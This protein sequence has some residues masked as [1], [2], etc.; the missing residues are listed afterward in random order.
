MKHLFFVIAY[1]I[2]LVPAMAVSY[3]GSFG[4]SDLQFSTGERGYDL[5][6]MNSLENIRVVGAPQVPVKMMNFIIPTGMDVDDVLINVNSQT[7][8]ETYELLP[9]QPPI[10]TSD[11]WLP[12]P[13]IE[14]DSTYYNMPIYPPSVYEVINHGYFDG[15]ARIA[16][17]AIY[18]IQYMPQSH[19]VLLNTSINFSLSFQ[20][21]SQVPVFPVKRNSLLQEKYN[22]LLYSIVENPEDIQMYYSQ[23]PSTELLP[24]EADYVIVAPEVLIPSLCDFLTWKA[25]KGLNPTLPL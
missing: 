18:P 17:I 11:D 23:P 20:S 19:Q 2:V 14:P 3:S 25:A 5:V 22:S 24:T 6:R 8:S 1:W 4:V 15:N 9:V 10:L 7:L 12:G 16:T 21:S 13:F